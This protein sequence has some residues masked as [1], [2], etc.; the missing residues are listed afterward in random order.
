MMMLNL[1]NLKSCSAYF[2]NSIIGKF[3]MTFLLLHTIHYFSSLI[4]GSW[5]L[6]TSILGYFKNIINGHG[7]ICHTLMIVSYHAQSN[8]YTFIGKTA[9]GTSITWLSESL[10]GKIIPVDETTVN[11][12][13]VNRPD[14]NKYYNH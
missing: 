6:D 10:F 2:L 14:T 1:S 3:I 13:P 4:Y 5:C 8:I 11:K 12:R 7:P 9:I